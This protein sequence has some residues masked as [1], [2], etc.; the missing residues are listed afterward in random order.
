MHED[1]PMV[2]RMTGMLSS[3]SLGLNNNKP[4]PRRTVAWGT[5]SEM[6]GETKE[7]GTRRPLQNIQPESQLGSIHVLEAVQ[8]SRKDKEL[9][10]DDIKTIV[11]PVRRSSRKSMVTRNFGGT[12]STPSTTVRDKIEQIEASTPTNRLLAKNGWAFKPNSTIP[13]GNMTPI[14]GSAATRRV[15][16]DMTPLPQS[17]GF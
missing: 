1:M 10:G 7:V 5:V 17:D 3:M 2:E 15:P 9:L 14:K 8:A 13:L 11:T 16:M 6:G 12:P 4:T